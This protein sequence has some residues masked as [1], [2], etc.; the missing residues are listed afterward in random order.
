MV[1]VPRFHLLLHSVRDPEA[2]KHL[3]PR[4]ILESLAEDTVPVPNGLER[5]LGSVLP[6]HTRRSG[7]SVL[8]SAG[9]S[10]QGAVEAAEPGPR[11]GKG[12]VSALLSQHGRGF[13]APR[14]LP[15]P[16]PGLPELAQMEG[17]PAACSPRQAPN[18]RLHQL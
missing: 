3:P 7:L 18:Y 16:P 8:L 10:P 12:A 4:A 15:P 13:G 9:A 6:R 11:G 5:A 1:P 14:L 17:V 2:P